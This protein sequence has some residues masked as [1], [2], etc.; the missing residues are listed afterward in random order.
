MP[1]YSCPRCSE[2]VQPGF[3]LC[4]YCGARLADAPADLP[5]V[6][7]A[8]AERQGRRDLGRVGT[9]LIVLGLLGFV[10]VILALTHGAG[11]NPES[12]LVIG[13]GTIVMVIA[14]SA[15]AAGRR[16]GT[17]ATGVLGGCASALMATVL[18]FVLAMAMVIY[19]ISGCFK[20]LSGGR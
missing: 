5:T 2:P 19:A 18:G 8:A 20:A 17:V 15:M 12:V 7:P 14:G 6:L 16:G 1:G 13:G 4:P 3:R 9:G 11:L 10:G